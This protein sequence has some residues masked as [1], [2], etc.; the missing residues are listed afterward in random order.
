MTN[1]LNLCK[2]FLGFDQFVTV[3]DN[4]RGDRPG[5]VISKVAFWYNRSKQRKQLGNLDER[6]L[7]DIGITAYQA[8]LEAN[9][10]FWMD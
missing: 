6:M 8:E 9:K 7:K 1:Y 2:A 10:P 5:Q 4:G 3:A